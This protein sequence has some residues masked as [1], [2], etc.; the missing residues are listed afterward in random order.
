C[1]IRQLGIPTVSVPMGVMADTK[2]PVNLTFAGKAYDDSALFKY[3]FAFEKATC[4]RQQPE[5][6]PALP[7][8][9]IKITGSTHK[10]GN[11]PPELTVDKV[12]ASDEGEPRT[13]HLS[14]TVDG[15]NLSAMQVYLDGDEV[16]R[17]C[18]SNGVWSSDVRIAADV[19]WSRVRKEEKRVPDLS[20]VMVIVLATGQNGRSA[21]EMIFV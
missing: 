10:L 11:S 17:V 18:V 20:K 14:G 3:A 6:T 5:R 13:I 12:E 2:M 7:T 21:A 16:N 8:D 4:L 1:A 9:T 15:E 19:D